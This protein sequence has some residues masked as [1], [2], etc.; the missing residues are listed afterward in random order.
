MAVNSGDCFCSRGV[1]SSAGPG[2][3]GAGVSGYGRN[4]S[5]ADAVSSE[6]LLKLKLNMNFIIEI[7]VNVVTEEHGDKVR[8]ADDDIKF[9]SSSIKTYIV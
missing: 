2:V 3:A 6:V 7:Q 1:I 8:Y 9:S 5:E 4:S